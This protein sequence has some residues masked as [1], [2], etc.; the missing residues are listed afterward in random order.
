MIV[1]NEKLGFIYFPVFKMSS[2]KY[3]S[4]KLATVEKEQ[5]VGIVKAE[6][7]L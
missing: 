7:I 3:E 5:F 2:F 4:C 6:I 1:P